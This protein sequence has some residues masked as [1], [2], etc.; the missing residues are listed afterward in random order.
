VL[1]ADLRMTEQ[2]AGAERTCYR[3]AFDPAR[4]VYTIA[5]FAGVVANGPPHCRAGAWEGPLFADGTAAGASRR[6]PAGV[7]LRTTSFPSH[8]VTFSPLGNPPAGTVVLRA[9]LAPQ[10]RITVE[11][12][13]YVRLADP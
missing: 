3:I 9:G 13:G 8:T 6:M 12:T 4:E 7:D 2:R 10:R 1:V 5:R 11:V